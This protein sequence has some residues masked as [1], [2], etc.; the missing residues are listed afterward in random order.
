[1]FD[2]NPPTNEERWQYEGVRIDQYIFGEVDYF[3]SDDELYQETHE[4]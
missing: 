4:E 3:E 2:S 1:M